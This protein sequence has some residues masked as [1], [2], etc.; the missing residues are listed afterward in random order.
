MIE[1]IL[2]D[3]MV[4]TSVNSGVTLLDFIRNDKNLTGTKT[5]SAF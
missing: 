1:F 2:N 4:K 3:K 5:G